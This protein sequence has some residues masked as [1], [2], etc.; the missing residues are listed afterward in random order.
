MTRQEI[1]PNAGCRR[2]LIIVLV[3]FHCSDSLCRAC[4]SHIRLPLTPIWFTVEI[5]FLSRADFF[6]HILYI[7][8]FLPFSDPKFNY[9]SFP[10]SAGW[11]N[12]TIQTWWKYFNRVCLVKGWFTHDIP[13]RLV[14]GVGGV[15]NNM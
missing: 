15:H 12:K 2:K 14:V 11:T 10:D 4:V 3:L 9:Q 13:C 1:K 6:P 5:P 7:F 8:F